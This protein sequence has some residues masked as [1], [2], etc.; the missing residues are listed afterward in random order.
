MENSIAKTNW[1]KRLE[2][3]RLYLTDEK[4][5]IVPA[6]V[7]KFGEE[8]F[9]VKD[10]K[11]FLNG[12]E[13][14]VDEKRKTAIISAEEDKFGGQT[15]AFDRLR[16]KYIGIS[17]A[18][19]ER[20]FRGSERR[21]LKARYTPKKENTLYAGRPGQIEIDLTF[22]RNQKLPVFGA[23]DVYSRY[24]Y[25]ERVPNKRA[26]SVVV[27]LEKFIKKF[28]S[29]SNF[30]VK[31]VKTDSGVEF[32][33]EFAAF[34]KKNG[35]YYDRKVKSRKLIENLN[36]HLRRYVERVGW[37]TIADLDK[38]IESFTETYN[39]SKHTVTKKTPNELV[40]TPK[41]KIKDFALRKQAKASGFTKAELKVNDKVRLY[42]P[43]RK[44]IKA[45]DKEKLKGKIKLSNEDYVK[46]FT[47]FH[48]GQAPHWTKKTFTIKKIIV[49]KKRATRYLL[50]EK[51]GQWFRHELQKAYKITK[52]D[53]RKKVQEKREADAA[54]LKSLL[55]EP[56]RAAKYIGKVYIVKYGDEDKPRDNDPATVLDVYKNFLILFH[57]SLDF[58]FANEK[59]LARATGKSYSK[60]DVK[61]WLKIN[62]EHVARVK[63]EIDKTIEEIKE[64]I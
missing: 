8:N 57:D 17:R 23:I 48:R 46:R 63:K 39:D 31:I 21:Q 13:I 18:D 51:K 20:V 1:K 59:E 43:R 45:E 6:L 53:P 49:G 41:E 22:Y 38:L 60:A 3:V 5:T 24:C 58:C 27:I 30:K 26:G 29:I 25:Y 11:V 7:K 44:E 2:T 42:D 19:V 10:K 54:K 64:S 15:K 61:H 9:K 16:R 12:K 37:D 4:R 34:L 50:V 33:K 36:G 28:E 32:Q 14:V 55:P 62:P 47:S 56:V 52:T 40:A 35:I